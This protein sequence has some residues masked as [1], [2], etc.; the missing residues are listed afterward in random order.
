MTCDLT[1]DFVSL[2]FPI[3]REEEPDKLMNVRLLAIIVSAI[4][5]PMV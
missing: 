5:G 3:I 1:R 2:S 4:V